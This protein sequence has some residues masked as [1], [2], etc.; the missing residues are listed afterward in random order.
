MRP[1]ARILGTMR[2][3]AGLASAFLLLATALLFVLEIVEALP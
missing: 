2:G 1:T 3:G